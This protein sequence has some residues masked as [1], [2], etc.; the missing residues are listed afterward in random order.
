MESSY[1]IV[2]AKKSPSTSGGSDLIWNI[3]T[4]LVLLAA[5]IC[6]LV[7]LN[8][9]INPNAGL[10]PFPP[11]TMPQRVSPPTAT[12]TPRFVIEATWTM[13]P[14]PEPSLTPTPKPTST[15]FLTEA[16]SGPSTET[17]T[18][19]PTLKPG[20]FNFVVQQGSPQAI[21]NVIRNEAGCN[22]MGVAGQAFSLNKS[23]VV[24]LFIQLGG[25][26]N[27]QLF[28]TLLSMTG[29]AIEYGQGGYEFVISDKPLAS[30]K[31]LW[32][33][34]LDQ[35]NL[36]LSDKIYFDTFSECEKNLILINFSQVK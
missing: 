34:L 24:G 15:V 35:S 5:L 23:P 9:F 6:G 13:E 2:E 4:L 36:P 27:G 7:M 10:N 28:E 1:D 17:P 11:P 21:P 16:P 14:T 29:T 32:V 26:L 31:T 33:Q 22:W 19:S 18:A 3:L 30:S 8:I 25:T 20:Q 12:V